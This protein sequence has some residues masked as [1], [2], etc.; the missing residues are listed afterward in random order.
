[1]EITPLHS[2]LG[3]RARIYLNKQKKEI[4][5]ESTEQKEKRTSDSVLGRNMA[6]EHG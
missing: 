3:D 1:M 5:R 4:S 6:G 2:N